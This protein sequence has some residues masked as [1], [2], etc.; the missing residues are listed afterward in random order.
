MCISWG[1]SCRSPSRSVEACLE[2]A[3]RSRLLRSTDENRQD[4]DLPLHRGAGRCIQVPSTAEVLP[5][6]SSQFPNRSEI[7]IAFAQKSCNPPHLFFPHKPG[8]VLVIAETETYR[9]QAETVVRMGSPKRLGRTRK[10][11]TWKKRETDHHPQLLQLSARN[12]ACSALFWILCS[13]VASCSKSATKFQ[14]SRSLHVY[15]RNQWLYRA[16]HFTKGRSHTLR[17][18]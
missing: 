13:L 12:A 1:C 7:P 8:Y 16:L 18:S 10:V 9:P 3:P 15:I 17:A 5:L 14:E 6:L 4:M 2:Q 11:G